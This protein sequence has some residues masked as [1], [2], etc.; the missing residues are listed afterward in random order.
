M[1]RRL[2]ARLWQRPGLGREITL[3]LLVK[4]LLMSLLFSALSRG[5]APRD[6]VAALAVEHLLGPQAA[7]ATD[8]RNPHGR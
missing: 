5:P 1:W 7:A 6:G 3:V 8:K 2:L 4:T